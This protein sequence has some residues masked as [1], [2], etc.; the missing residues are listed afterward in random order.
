MSPKRL[1]MYIMFFECVC[2]CVRVVTDIRVASCCA[3]AP[4]LQVHI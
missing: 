2:V 1:Y 4:A 3:K